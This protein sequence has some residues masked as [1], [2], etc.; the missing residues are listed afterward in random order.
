M[1]SVLDKKEISACIKWTVG[2]VQ[3]IFLANQ[4]RGKKTFKLK[5][6]ALLRPKSGLASLV[7]VND[8]SVLERMQL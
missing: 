4:S 8:V 1:S 6:L 5:S 3:S 7:D 2:N